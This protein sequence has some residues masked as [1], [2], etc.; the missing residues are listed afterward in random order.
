MSSSSAP[1]QAGEARAGVVAA[2]AAARW[3]AA[4][5]GAM[6]AA[7]LCFVGWRATGAGDGSAVTTV[8]DLAFPVVG[9]LAL[10]LAVRAVR[11]TRPES[12]ERTAWKLLAASLVAYTTGDVL[13]AILELSSGKGP[14]VS[15]ADVA[16]LLFYP[17]ALAGLVSLPGATRNRLEQALFAIDVLVVLILGVAVEWILVIGPAVSTAG[18]DPAA[19]AVSLAYPI[20]D[21]VLLLG[22]AVVVVRREFSRAELPVAL[23]VVAFAANL[24]GD[25]VS[26]SEVLDAGFVTGGVPDVCFLVFWLAAG[27]AMYTQGRA[28]DRDPGHGRRAPTRIAWL[29]YGAMIGA[30]VLPVAAVGART[31]V[32]PAMVGAGAVGLLIIVRQALV[33]R[34]GAAAAAATAALAAQARFDALVQEAS[35]LIVVVGPDGVVQYC[36]PSAWRTLGRDPGSMVGVPFASLACAEDAARLSGWLRDRAAGRGGDAR[37]VWRLAV[38]GAS[39]RLVESV[40]SCPLHDAGPGVV[41]TSRDIS[42]RAQLED[43]LNEARRL[44]A[45]G[46]LA[47]GVAHDFNNILTAVGGF[48]EFALADLEH[49]GAK[50]E[51]LLQIRA[52]A[53]RAARITTDLLAFGQRQ[54]VRPEPVDLAD[55]VADSMP[56]IEQAIGTSIKVATRFGRAVPPVLADRNQ[57]GQVLVNLAANARDAMPDGGTLVIRVESPPA[58]GAPGAGDA[59][60]SG[61]PGGWVE[62]SVTDTGHGMDE[63]TR[64]RL[65]EPFFTTKGL[66]RGRRAR[67]GE[68]VRDRHRGR[69]VHLGRQPA[70]PRDDVPNPPARR[71]RP[72]GGTVGAAAPA[73][74]RPDRVPDHARR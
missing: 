19:V 41:V 1:G 70:G 16:Y 37:L 14:E 5:V 23:L 35:D 61:G 40:G 15:V 56:L 58:G 68:R 57:V 52:A 6:A 33:A 4:V 36:A 20:G 48:A 17:L 50:R 18:D 11:R 2:E 44:E 54:F 71:G 13:W 42:E 32:A 69:R 60:A 27:L 53:D 10:A 26:G 25:V 62:L 22:V 29:P 51:D 64:S 12:G 24:V 72:G 46:R 65:F 31:P 55:A 8:T 45:V 21:L 39:D 30:F 67:A 74:G 73:A 49:G 63:A 47:S 34:Q 9:V 38:P 28:P 59:P 66:A 43:E 3:P 7:V